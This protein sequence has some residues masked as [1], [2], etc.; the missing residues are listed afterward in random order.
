MLCLQWVLVF[1]GVKGK[2]PKCPVPCWKRLQMEPHLHHDWR[3]CE[4]SMEIGN[5]SGAL[6]NIWTLLNPVPPFNKDT[7]KTNTFL[8]NLPVRILPPALIEGFRPQPIRFL[9]PAYGVGEALAQ[10]ASGDLH[11]AGHTE[12]RVPRRAAAWRTPPVVFRGFDRFTCLWV[13][14]L[15]FLVGS[16]STCCLSVSLSFFRG[17]QQRR[18]GPGKPA[19]PP[20]CLFS[21]WPVWRLRGQT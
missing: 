1:G 14:S 19:Q 18:W 4:S 9:R 3:F 20:S 8:R 13:R 2:G 6:S 12:L 21:G 11:A 10:R 5:L 15:L 7:K 17:N 16:F